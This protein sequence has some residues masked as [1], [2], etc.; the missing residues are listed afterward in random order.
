M[1]TCVCVGRQWLAALMVSNHDDN[2]G[3]G[4]GLS[5]CCFNFR[6][7]YS[8]FFIYS[9]AYFLVWIYCTSNWIT[10]WYPL[11]NEIKCTRL[12]ACVYVLPGWNKLCHTTLRKNPT[13]L[14]F[15]LW[16]T[17]DCLI[18]CDF[19]RHL[20][21]NRTKWRK[22]VPSMDEFKKNIT[23][24]ESHY[25]SLRWKDKPFPVFPKV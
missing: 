9:H 4:F 12:C 19:L 22:S 20:S 8:Y 10:H 11:N 1:C 6:D 5:V 15:L 24:Y 3:G 25:R 16:T 7:I 2:D 17:D 23:Y 18:I 14:V 21:I 13:R